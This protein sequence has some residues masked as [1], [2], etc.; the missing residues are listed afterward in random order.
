MIESCGNNHEKYNQHISDKPLKMIFN[1][2]TEQAASSQI[3]SNNSILSK[4]ILQ[5]DTVN[6]LL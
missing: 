5:K 2:K 1:K 6:W 3:Y 4:H